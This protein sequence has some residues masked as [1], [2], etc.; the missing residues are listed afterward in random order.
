MIVTTVLAE[1]EVARVVCRQEQHQLMLEL[2]I[3]LPLAQEVQA[4]VQ[5]KHMLEAIVVR[6]VSLQQEEE[7]VGETT[8][9]ATKME[10]QVVVVRKVF[11]VEQE[12]RDKEIVVEVRHLAHQMLVA[13]VV[14][15]VLEVREVMELAPLEEA[16]V[17]V[18]QVQSQVHQL[19]M[20]KEA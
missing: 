1:G 7:E 3:L 18:P 17:L 8:G 19:L 4:Q 6:L 9:R 16:L 11:L 13:V 14:V 12:L 15:G 5:R 20:Q 10:V 2:D